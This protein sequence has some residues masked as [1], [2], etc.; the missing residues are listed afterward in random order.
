MTSWTVE[1]G[2]AGWRVLYDGDPWPM[3]PKDTREE[4][5]AYA[6]RLAERYP[7]DS[8][9]ILMDTEGTE[10]TRGGPWRWTLE[11]GETGLI[12]TSRL[13]DAKAVLRHKMRR[14]RLPNGI[15]WDLEAGR[16][17]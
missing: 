1:R 8:A 2:G 4:A 5:E 10:R 17:T 15:A 13:A 6:G 16:G 11:N 3:T 9:R 7:H 12:H 14:K